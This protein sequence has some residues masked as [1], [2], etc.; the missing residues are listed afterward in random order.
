MKILVNYV[1]LRDFESNILIVYI[2]I[3]INPYILYMF[4]GLV[5]QDK[6]I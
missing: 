5:F 2:I 1:T 3:I 6:P 4:Y